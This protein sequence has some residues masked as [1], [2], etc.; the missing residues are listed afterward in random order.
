MLV[1]YTGAENGGSGPSH[2]RSSGGMGRGGGGGGV[3]E[4]ERWGRARSGTARGGREQ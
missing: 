2:L 1:K 3:G 4:G